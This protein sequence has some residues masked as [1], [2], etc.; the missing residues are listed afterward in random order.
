MKRPWV[1]AV[2]AVLVT[3]CS[4]S[5]PAPDPSGPTGGSTGAD[6]AAPEVV[7]D[8]ATDLGAPWGMAA[9]GHGDTLL[10]HRDTAE[11]SAI[12]ANGSVRSAGRIDGVVPGAEGGLLGIAV[13]PRKGGAP[14]D[15]RST[16]YVYYT[17][18]SDNRIDELQWDGRQLGQQ[19]TIFSGIPKSQ[20]H[21]GG[22]IAFGPDG[23]LYVGTGDAGQG[24]SAQDPQS[25]GGKILR[26]TGDGEP[27]PGNPDSGSSVYSLGHR[28]VQGLAWDSAGR[29]WASEFG[30]DDADELNLIEPGGNYGWPECEGECGR[31]DRIDPAL[32]WSPTSI[33][34]PS[35]MAIA[36][37]SA[38]I[39]SLRGETLWEVPLQGG[40]TG[41]PRAWFVGEFGRLRDVIVG[42]D[43]DLWLATNNTDGRGSPRPGDDRIVRITPGGDAGG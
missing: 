6:A 8:A 42:P 12:G 35:G 36:G 7:G 17:A 14:D 22:R 28:N 13:A 15:T 19:R 29:L 16:V 25:L 32:V 41:E 38:W 30:Q 34:S 26:I 11:V 23:F 10:T 21:N 39:A 31:T 27:A 24:D 33:A 5:T 37:D 9:T 1:A 40:S 18:A 43:G 2:A 3:A 4:T 20:I